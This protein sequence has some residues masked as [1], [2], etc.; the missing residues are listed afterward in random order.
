MKPCCYLFQVRKSTSTQSSGQQHT[1]VL[2]R[3]VKRLGFTIVGG[4]DSNKGKMG[5]FVKNVL[6]DGRAGGLLKP[7]DE[8]LAVNGIS[9]QGATH[10][11]A[12]QKIRSAKKG[13]MVFLVARR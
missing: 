12:L 13:K 2:E 9:L 4:V 11:V 8:L 10:V 3:S 5:I 6:S 7:G 1:V